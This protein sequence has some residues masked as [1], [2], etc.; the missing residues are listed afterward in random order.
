MPR[1]AGPVAIGPARLGQQAG[2]APWELGHLE[3]FGPRRD[4]CFQFFIHF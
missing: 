3:A 2:L 1:W 4:F